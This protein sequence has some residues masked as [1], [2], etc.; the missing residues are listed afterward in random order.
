MLRL[1]PSELTLTPED[2]DEAFR[3]MTNRQAL[4]VSRH[5]SWQ[6]GRPV[7]HR[8]PQRAVQD[9]VTSLGDI[10]V[11]RPRPQRAAQSSVDDDNEDES[12]QTTPSPRARNDSASI[13]VF[14]M[15]GERAVSANP[16]TSAS[17]ALRILHLPFRLGRGHGET[18]NQSALVEHRFEEDTASPSRLPT[19]FLEPS[20]DAVGVAHPSQRAS[21]ARPGTASSQ[22][23]LRGGGQPTRD[24]ARVLSQDASS[25]TSPSR[26]VRLPSSPHDEEHPHHDAKGESSATEESSTR[27]LVSYV[28]GPS[29]GSDRPAFAFHEYRPRGSQTEPRRASGRLPNLVRSLSSGGAPTYS[30]HTQSHEQSITT[31]DDVFG[32]PS[33]PPREL[34]TGYHQQSVH[35]QRHPPST[36]IPR[37][38]S[39]EASAASEPFSIYELPPMSRQVSGDHTAGAEPIYPQYDGAV[40][41]RQVSHGAYHAVR[42]SDIRPYYSPMQ[43]SSIASSVGGQH[44][45]SPLPSM[46]YTRNPNSYTMPQALPGRQVVTPAPTGYTDAATAAMQGLVSPLDP[47][48]EHYQHLMEQQ[49]ARQAMH[50][51]PVAQ[52]PTDRYSAGARHSATEVARRMSDRLPPQH[53][54]LPTTHHFVGAPGHPPQPMGRNAHN[55]RTNQRSSENAPVRPS[56]QTRVPSRNSVVQQNR[57][58]FEAMRNL[59]N[60]EPPQQRPSRLSMP[61]STVPHDTSNQPQAQELSGTATSRQQ[62]RRRTPQISSSPIPPFEQPPSAQLNPP[63][64][65]TSPRMPP[66]IPPRNESNMRGGAAPDRFQTRARRRV[67]PARSPTYLQPPRAGPPTSLASDHISATTRLRSPLLRATTSARPPRRVPAQQRD[68]E[69]SGAGEEHLMRREEAAIHARYGEDEQRD[70]MDETPPRVGRVERRMFS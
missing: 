50:A 58:V 52:H 65:G 16:N 23:E 62:M 12:E 30:L 47:F 51:F 33:V 35:N 28:T 63:A 32:T 26:R 9:A 14:P 10:P 67:T 46:P 56:V 21:P 5:A 42:P 40:A 54:T 17:S 19:S 61:Q 37:Q 8:G 29:K 38:F 43:Q 13:S 59:G 70:V 44:G 24:H 6:P 57:A 4:R 25:T 41:S 55:T 31:S 39:S 20:D 11:L 2:V 34:H 45:I 18:P 36:T 1:R 27:L 66:T 60:T 7:L 15:H 69:N 49:N 3:R 22:V 48:S 64:Q 68:Q 53:P